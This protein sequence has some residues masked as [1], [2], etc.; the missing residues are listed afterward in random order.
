MTFFNKQDPVEKTTGRV[1]VIKLTLPGNKVIYKI[2]MTHSPRSTDR[3]MEILRSWFMQYRYVPHAELRLD[4]ETGVPLLLEKHM[5]EVLSEWKYVPD[6]KV[7]GAQE[8]FTDIN[9]E[10]LLDYLKHFDY[11]LL[12]RCTKIKCQDYDYIHSQI[13]PTNL[14]PVED[15]P[16]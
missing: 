10:Y 12:L 11:S 16:F 1:Y 7:D 13:N 6:K 5:H 8:M 9:E 15:I 3:M 14:D 2:G 4:K